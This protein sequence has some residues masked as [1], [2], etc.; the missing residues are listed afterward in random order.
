MSANE[1]RSLYITWHKTQLQ[2]DHRAQS[3]KRFTKPDRKEGIVL[4]L[5]AQERA[6]LTGHG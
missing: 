2:V 4:N 5:L 3:E 6:F 1:N